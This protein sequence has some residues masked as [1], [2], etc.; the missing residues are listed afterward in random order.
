MENSNGDFITSMVLVLIILIIACAS[1][2]KEE[3][4]YERAEW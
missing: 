4:Q 1:W 2:C 3:Q